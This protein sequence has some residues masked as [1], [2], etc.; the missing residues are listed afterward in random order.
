MAYRGAGLQARRDDSAEPGYVYAMGGD[1]GPMKVG[2][3]RNLHLRLYTNSRDL[4]RSLRLLFWLE[5][6]GPALLGVERLAHRLLRERHVRDELFDVSA[7]EAA[8]AI[9]EARA[10]Y[11]AGERAPKASADPKRPSASLRISLPEEILAAI[12]DWRA[13]Q[14]PG[15]PTRPDAIMRLIVMGLAREGRPASAHAPDL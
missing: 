11:E 8:S 2:Y 12:E 15:I 13:A 9:R 1:G 3:S 7:D 5:V 10:R 4:G 14:R 6:P